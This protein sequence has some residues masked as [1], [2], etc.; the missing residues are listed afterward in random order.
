MHSIKSVCPGCVFGA[1]L[2]HVSGLD[3]FSKAFVS[4]CL[5][6]DRYATAHHKDTKAQRT[7]KTES[8][9]RYAGNSFISIRILHKIIM[10]KRK[11]GYKAISA[12]EISQYV[13]CPV[14]WYLKRSG[15]QPQSF[16]LK[17]GIDA[18]EK[19]GS[20]LI[21]LE[22]RERAAGMFRLLG[23]FSAIAAILLTGWV[24]WTYF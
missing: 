16:G 3:T 23:Y 13:Y 4:L 24:L 9:V 19:A 15:V 18:H 2:F 14:S 21:L 8:P 22:R 7:I 10:L 6:G 5:R 1:S 11:N 12:S 17:R 20:R